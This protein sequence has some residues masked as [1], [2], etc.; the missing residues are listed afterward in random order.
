MSL[1]DTLNIDL[2]VA[3]KSGQRERADL[4]RNLKSDLQYKEI[5]KKGP[6]TDDEIIMV[7][8]SAAKR[9][10]ESI[11]QFEKGGRADLVAREQGQLDLIAGY[12]PEALSEVELVQL[13]EKAVTESGAS[14]LSEMGKVMK[15]LMPEIGARA[16][17]KLVSRL[18]QTRL[19]TK[20]E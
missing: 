7:V 2:K 1:L 3:L 20:S 8:A 15:V 11:E 6:L 16:D 4:I 10:R 19:A 13:V 5:E 14:G 9:R 18:V 17:G 12:L